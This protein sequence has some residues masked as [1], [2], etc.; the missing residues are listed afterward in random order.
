MVLPA[1][2]CWSCPEGI[3]TLHP[4][5]W[6]TR[7]SKRAGCLFF[8]GFVAARLGKTLDPVSGSVSLSNIRFKALFVVKVIRLFFP[9][10]STESGMLGI[11]PQCFLQVHQTNT[12]SLNN[13]HGSQV[14]RMVPDPPRSMRSIDPTSCHIA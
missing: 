5:Q 11:S 13:V 1:K 7:I 3:L 6:P 4:E 10:R 2:A 8:L 14:G 12:N 9:F